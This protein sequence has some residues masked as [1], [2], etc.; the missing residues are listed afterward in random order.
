MNRRRLDQ[1]KKSARSGVLVRRVLGV[2]ARGVGVLAVTAALAYGAIAG[3]AWLRTSEHLA[4]KRLEI[5]GVHRAA[6]DELALA[7]GLVEGRNVFGIDLAGAALAMERNPWVRRARLFRDLP[8]GVRVEIEEHVPV[9]LV[10]VPGGL[11]AV[12]K[13]GML[14]KRV[15]AGDRLDLPIVSGLTR[16]TFAGEHRGG[17]GTLRTALALVARISE[18][19]VSENWLLSEL[20]VTTD[21]G[22][23][24]WTAWMGDEP[25]EV[26]LG[27]LEETVPGRLTALADERLDRLA[28]VRDELL[29]QRTRALRIDLGNRTNP[30]WVAV[31]PATNETVAARRVASTGK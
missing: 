28:R 20:Q 31:L 13:E 29:R 21:S 25:V 4:L 23:L 11:Y 27:A 19:R 12:T 3:W 6:A 26:R 22:E 15:L 5:R 16:E 1:S 2:L 9:A 14:F 30:D 10:S 7:A 24:A 17:D 8:D 18:H